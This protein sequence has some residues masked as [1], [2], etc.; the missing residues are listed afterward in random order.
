MLPF[1]FDSNTF[2]KMF[3]PFKRLPK[4][5]LLFRGSVSLKNDWKGSAGASW[6]VLKQKWFL[7]PPSCPHCSPI[8]AAVLILWWW[9]LSSWVSWWINHGPRPWPTITRL[10]FPSV[11]SRGVSVSTGWHRH[12]HPVGLNEKF[13]DLLLAAHICVLVLTAALWGKKTGF[14]YT[15]Q[16]QKTSSHCSCLQK[17]VFISTLAMPPITDGPEKG[18]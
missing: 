13:S 6:H 14:Q 5:F 11:E 12:K 3:Q 9:T 18:L 4:W 16:G 8:C 15:F 2:L 17:L 1:D 7:Y 10:T